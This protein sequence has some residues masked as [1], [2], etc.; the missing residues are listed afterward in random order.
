MNNIP[1]PNQRNP[2]TRSDLSN[3]VFLKNEITSSLIDVGDYTYYD[4]EGYRPAFEQANVKYLYG[5]R[6]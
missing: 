3:V 1:D 6:G 4:D 2:S 5:P